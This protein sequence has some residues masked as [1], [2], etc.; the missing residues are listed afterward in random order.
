MVSFLTSARS[1]TD[2]NLRLKAAEGKIAQVRAEFRS[3]RAQ[4]LAQ[5]E[6]IQ[7]QREGVAVSLLQLREAQ[8]GLI[9]AELRVN[10]DLATVAKVANLLSS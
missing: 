7:V 1:S 6:E 4:L 3:R 2:L 10:D 9:H 8:D 5:Q